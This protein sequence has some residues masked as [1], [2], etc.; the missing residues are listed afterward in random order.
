MSDTDIT[1]E[2]KPTPSHIG[3]G[4][5]VDYTS[6]E[7]DEAFEGDDEPQRVP[8][9]EDGADLIV[10]PRLVATRPGP[11]RTQGKIVLHTRAA[12]RLFYGRRRDDKKGIKP[13]IGLVR[14]AVNVN[15]IFDSSAK[16]DPYSDAIL[17]KIEERFIAVNTLVKENIEALE[18]LLG[19]MEGLNI[20]GDESTN[21]VELPV[22]FR[23]V[24]GFMGARL[25]GQYDKLMRL[26]LVARHVGLLLSDDW[27]RLIGKAGSKIREVFWLSA[28]YHYTGVTRDD[29][30]A[31]NE[32][33]RR[34]AEKYEELSQD[35]MEGTRRARHAPPL[36]EVKDKI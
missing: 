36:R 16:N 26:G 23:T 5:R 34:A 29:I 15:K 7:F 10:P 2:K 24:Y 27:G 20:C 14:F 32:V 31:N 1:E 11:I 4:H 19:G 8:T 28:T 30:A 35:V 3:T 12:H 22:E 18:Q 17:L 9:H 13:I 21:P 6:P 33:A 25:L